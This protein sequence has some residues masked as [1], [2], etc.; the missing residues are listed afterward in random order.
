MLTRCL[1]E[2]FKEIEN[3]F[4]NRPINYI[5][6]A[7]CGKHFRNQNVMGYFFNELKDLNIQGFSLLICK[8]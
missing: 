2:F 7:D 8:F 3:K 1:Q 5:I 6:W 4:Q